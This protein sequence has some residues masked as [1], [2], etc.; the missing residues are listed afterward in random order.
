MGWEYHER[1]RD[2]RGAF[3]KKETR[4]PVHLHLRVDGETADEL[5]RQANGAA[6]E[7]SEYVIQTLRLLWGM[8]P[9][10]FPSTEKTERARGHGK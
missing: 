6:M 3:T 9:L 10:G 8:P 7:L 4:R 5:R 2:L 1:P